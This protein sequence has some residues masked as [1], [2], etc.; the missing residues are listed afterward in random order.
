VAVVQAGYRSRFG[1]PAPEVLA[2]YAERGITVVRTDGCG[3]WLWHDGAAS[4]T[5][6][7]R[8]RYWHAAATGLAADTSPEGGANVAKPAGSGVPSP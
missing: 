7:V 5:R 2:R 3:A 4:C 1:H 6:D 8:R